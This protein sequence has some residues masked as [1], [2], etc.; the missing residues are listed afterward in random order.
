[1]L[2]KG[3]ENVGDTNKYVVQQLYTPLT[4]QDWPGFEPGSLDNQ[5]VEENV[6]FYRVCN[7]WPV[8]LAKTVSIGK[9]VA[10]SATYFPMDT[11]PTNRIWLPTQPRHYTTREKI[12]LSRQLLKMAQGGPKHVWELV[13]CVRPCVC[14]CVCVCL[15]ARSRKYVWVLILLFLLPVWNG[16]SM[17]FFIVDVYIKARVTIQ[18][19][20]QASDLLYLHRFLFCF[21][22]HCHHS[23]KFNFAAYVVN[24][25]MFIFQNLQK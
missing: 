5:Y 11:Q 2:A 9:Y 17:W 12:P 18:C 7:S 24:Y 16:V 6:F 10:R 13:N 19:E 25:S 1:M 22:L 14:M 3:T 15:C 20:D 4:A 23:Y 8:V 21:V